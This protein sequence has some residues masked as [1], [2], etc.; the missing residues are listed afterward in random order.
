MS[1]CAATGR[2]AVPDEPGPGRRAGRAG[3]GSPPSTTPH[4]SGSCPNWQK[5]S[6]PCAPR[7]GIGLDGAAPSCGGQ[8]RASGARADRVRPRP[9]RPPVARQPGGLA[10]IL[11]CQPDL[12]PRRHAARARPG[13]RPGPRDPRIR[14]RGHAGRARAQAARLRHR[15]RGA[16]RAIA[17]RR[18]RAGVPHRRAAGL[19]RPRRGWCSPCSPR[20]RG[21]SASTSATGPWKATSRPAAR[22]SRSAALPSPTTRCSPWRFTCASRS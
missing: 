21:A 19:A 8:H 18:H 9:D 7:A 11:G 17:G 2:V 14:S 16:R 4:G 3:A 12:H 22:A 1:S 10:A 13:R 5:H 20:C 15:A 6:D